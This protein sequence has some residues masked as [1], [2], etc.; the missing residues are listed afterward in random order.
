MFNQPFYH[1][2]IRKTLVGFGNLFSQIIVERREDDSVTGA[3]SQR[4]RVPITYSGKEKWIVRIDQDPDMERNTY[5]NLPLMAFE[6]VGISYD[7]QR[8]MNKNNKIVCRKEGGA[9][10]TYS[11]VPY[12]I[13]ISLYILA[14]TSE[15]MFQIVEQI[16]PTFGPEYVMSIK[17][18]PDMNIIQDVP[19]ILNSVLPSDEYDGDFQIRRFITYTLT[20][21]LKVNFFNKL[22]GSTLIETSMADI[23]SDPDF[24]N[25]NVSY[26]ADGDLNTGDITE[27]WT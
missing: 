9:T 13:E 22:S 4:L 12:N 5:I 18:V 24:T 17:A 20:F 16:M 14:K 19:V 15:D 7:A 8:K 25:L 26:R 3:V 2:V 10:D 1:A 11:P 23:F 6:I 27:S 21:T